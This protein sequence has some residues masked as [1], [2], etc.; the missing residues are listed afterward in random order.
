MKIYK[1]KIK[2]VLKIRSKKFIDN[3]GFFSEVYNKKLYKK[4]FV[5]DN[6]SF[7]KR[8][9][10]FRGLHFQVGAFKQAKL[11]RVE[12]GKII[13]FVLDLRKSSKTYL[14]LL[15]V[16]LSDKNFTQ[17]YIPWGCAHGFLTLE[18]NTKVFY[19]VDNYYSKI[20]SRGYNILDKKIIINEVNK[21]KI[22]LSKQDK[23]LPFLNEKI[24]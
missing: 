18:K 5:Q 10:T 15:K 9:F 19:K 17:L 3:R 2:D 7:N 14:T 23:N 13:D 20:H 1:T 8:I 21:K 11:I 6:L 12:S 24:K 22:H 16:I 4:K